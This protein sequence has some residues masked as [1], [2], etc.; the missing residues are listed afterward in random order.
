MKINNPFFKK[1]K[2]VFLNN[3][4][5]VLGKQKIKKKN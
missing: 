5:N 3:I 4:L 2:Y 1:Q